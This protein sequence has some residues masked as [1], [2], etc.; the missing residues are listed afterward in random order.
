MADAL[1][2]DLSAPHLCGDA[3]AALRRL[4]QRLEARNQ[5]AARSLAEGL[6]ETLALH[7][8]GMFPVVA[9]LSNPP[10]VWSR[11]MPW[12][13]SG[14]RTSITEGIPISGDVD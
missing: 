14:V 2:T 13:K 3:R 8:L 6:E 11:S 1:A 12:W 7:R 9:H 4:Q 10:I 5:W